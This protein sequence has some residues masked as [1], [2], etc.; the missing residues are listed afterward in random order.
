MAER[1]KRAAAWLGL[2][3]D[4]RYAEYDDAVDFEDMTEDDSPD[5]SLNAADKP[6]TVTPLESRRTAGRRFHARR[7]PVGHRRHKRPILAELYRRHCRKELAAHERGGVSLLVQEARL[8]AP[9]R[10]C[11]QAL[12]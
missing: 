10:R 7:D 9:V 5:E 11:A 6:A 2:V 4:D 3:T 12:Y 1:L 8:Y